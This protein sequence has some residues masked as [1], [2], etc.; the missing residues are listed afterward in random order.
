MLYPEAKARDLFSLNKLNVTAWKV[1]E[2]KRSM[3]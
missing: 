2:H 1:E 3:R